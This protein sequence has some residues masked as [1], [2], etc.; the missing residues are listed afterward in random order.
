[1]MAQQPDGTE[2]QI[3]EYRFN[4]TRTMPGPPGQDSLEST[5]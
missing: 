2:T 5:Q 4:H 1:M 3:A